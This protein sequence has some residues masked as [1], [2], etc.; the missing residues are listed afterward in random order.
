MTGPPQF[1]P[2]ALT[3]DGFGVNTLAPPYWPT[4]IRDPER[5]A[6]SKADLPNVM[7]PQTHEHIGDK[8]SKRTSIGPGTPARGRRRWSSTR[9]PAAFR[10]SPI[11]SITISRSTTSS[12]KA[13]R[14]PT[15]A[16]NACAMPAWG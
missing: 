2:S 10:K 14:I 13:R 8:L 7:V 5:P 4:W 12:S 16:V 11:S 15:S 3:P 9:I 1:G 6:Y